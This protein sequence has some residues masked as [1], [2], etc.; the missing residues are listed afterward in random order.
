MAMCYQSTGWD[1]GGLVIAVI[2]K[3]DQTMITARR[4][5][6]QEMTYLKRELFSGLD[7]ILTNICVACYEWFSLQ[8]EILIL[9]S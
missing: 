2:A 8:T 4:E 9:K 3:W 5:R 6:E 1:F 7:K